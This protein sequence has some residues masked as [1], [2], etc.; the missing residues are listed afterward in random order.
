M[1]N[2]QNDGSFDLKTKRSYEKLK[3]KCATHFSVSIFK[4]WSLISLNRCTSANLL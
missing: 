1:A 4:C 2:T 3:Y